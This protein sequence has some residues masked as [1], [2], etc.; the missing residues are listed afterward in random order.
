MYER[1]GG[2]YIGAYHC[3]SSPFFIACSHI[4][5][6]YSKRKDIGA[7]KLIA[8]GKI[9]LKNDSAIS[10][11]GELGIEFEDGSTLPADVV[12]FATGCANSPKRSLDPLTLDLFPP[13]FPYKKL[14][15]NE[16][17]RRLLHYDI[18]PSSHQ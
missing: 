10:H 4:T 6:S 8:E 14:L 11:F 5:P 2:Y 7:S 13:S 12:I 1:A 18:L 16:P 15:C 17:K 9:K 3:L